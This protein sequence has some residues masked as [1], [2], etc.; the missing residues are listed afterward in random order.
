MWI[1]GSGV[2]GQ[3][4]SRKT[5]EGAT[6]RKQRLWIPPSAG[7]TALNGR[8]QQLVADVLLLLN[9]ADRGDQPRDSERRLNRS[10]RHDLPPC[11]TRYRPALGSGLT[12]GTAASSAPGIGCVDP[13]AFE[14]CPYPPNRTPPAC[15][16]SQPFSRTHH[17]L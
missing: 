15:H 6:Y 11:I 3:V 16:I 12:V 1:D 10:N 7:W 13:C 8:A 17:T 5:S 14:L 4:G 2:V 9:L